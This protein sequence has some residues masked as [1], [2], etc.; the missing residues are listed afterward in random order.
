ML[1]A[2]AGWIIKLVTGIFGQWYQT[3]KI[4]DD[5]K[6]EQQVQDDEKA[7]QNIAVAQ[8]ARDDVDHQLATHPDSLRDN[9]PDFRD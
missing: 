6:Q 5:G 4:K 2:I 8:A 7:I 1:S 9:D 3:E